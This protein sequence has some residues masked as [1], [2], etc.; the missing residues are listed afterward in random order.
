MA[1]TVTGL[2]PEPFK[3]LYGLPEDA[4]ARHLARR[5]IA[6]ESGFPERV[7]LR[8][9]APGES[10]LLVHYEHQ[11]ADTP[12]RA[13]H[14]IYVR[15]GAT[16]PWAGDHIPEVLRKR[17]LSLR[18]FSADGMMVEAD[19]VEGVEAESLIDKQLA[20]PAVAYIQAHYARPGCYAAR[21]DRA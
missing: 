7:E 3:H 14:A 5:V 1:F 16:E 6:G 8:D 2:S 12:Y 19:V 10:L 11:D 17:L 15:E 9:A 21:I 18:A 13:S 4:L 20:N